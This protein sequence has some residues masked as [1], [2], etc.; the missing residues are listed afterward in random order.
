MWMSARR[1][2]V[3]TRFVRVALGNTNRA[4]SPGT[5]ASTS[6][7]YS[8][9][10][11]VDL[12][13]VALAERGVALG[14]RRGQHRRG[15]LELHV[16]LAL[17]VERDAR[18]MA[19]ELVRQ[20][21]RHARQ[22]EREHDVLDGGAVAGLDDV[23]RSA[24]A[25]TPASIS[26][27]IASRKISCGLQLRV[28]GPARRVDERHVELLDD[29]LG[30]GTA[31]SPSCPARCGPGLRGIDVFGRWGAGASA[32]AEVYRRGPA[33]NTPNRARDAVRST[34][35]PRPPRPAAGPGPR[36]G[37]TSSRGSSRSCTG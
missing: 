25:S 37:T 27:A 34:L 23:A 29:L 26:P 2:V 5:P 30:R 3:M 28:A 33:A 4:S 24:A 7:P 22:R 31:A 1:L 15:A 19:D 32:M 10:R 11:P 21:P 6:S 9:E 8:D 14:D 17:L 16:A 35:T 13:L 18:P 20:R 12:G 36:A